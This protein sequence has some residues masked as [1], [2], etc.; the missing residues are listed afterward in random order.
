MQYYSQKTKKIY[1]KQEDCLA[2]EKKY[3]AAMKEQEDKAQKL[4][5]E[6]GARSKEV[7]DAYEAIIDAQRHYDEVLNAFIK[8][9]GIYHTTITTFRPKTLVSIFDEM[10]R[11]Y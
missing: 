10:I 8:D 9:Y 5:E 4:K 3:D 1:D 2:D 7:E 6:R 11:N